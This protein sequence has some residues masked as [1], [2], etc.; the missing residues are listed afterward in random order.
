[1]NPAVLAVLAAAPNAAP[2]VAAGGIPGINIGFL[3]GMGLAIVSLIGIF[4]VAPKV[5]MKA[6]KS[7]LKGG[8]T[9]GAGFVVAVFVVVLALSVGLLATFGQGFLAQLFS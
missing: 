9:S 6:S 3:T 7:D 8:M 4:V 1:M 5:A 2:D